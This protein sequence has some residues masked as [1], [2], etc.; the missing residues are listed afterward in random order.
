MPN[1]CGINQKLLAEKLSE[2]RKMPSQKK[3][4]TGMTPNNTSTT[5]V[6]ILTSC[7]CVVIEDACNTLV[8]MLVLTLVFKLNIFPEFREEK[9]V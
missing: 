7:L 5:S 4:K 6:S 8:F 1:L 3:G 9:A 2:V